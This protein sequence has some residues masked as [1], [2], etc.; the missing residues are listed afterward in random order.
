MAR[1]SLTW[2]EEGILTVYIGRKGYC[3]YEG[4]IE[5]YCK[6]GSVYRFND[7]VELGPKVIVEWGK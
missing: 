4:R 7:E 3:L 5:T 1:N 2:C 6:L